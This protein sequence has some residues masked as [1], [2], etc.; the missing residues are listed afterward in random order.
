MKRIFFLTGIFF[1][2]LYGNAQDIISLK[3]TWSVKTDP[4]K[5]GEQQQWYKQVFEQTIQLPGTLD[6]AGIGQ[7]SQLTAD[8]LNRDVLLHLTRKHSY[9]GHAWYAKE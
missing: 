5:T 8:S 4:Q 1:C 6:D 2:S 9:V 3:G 7:A